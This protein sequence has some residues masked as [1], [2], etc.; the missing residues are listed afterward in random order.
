MIG[1]FEDLIFDEI[2]EDPDQVEVTEPEDLSA[3][4]ASLKEYQ[5]TKGKL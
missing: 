4:L 3:D 2:V 5:R 1:T